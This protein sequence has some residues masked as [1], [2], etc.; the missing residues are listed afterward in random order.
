MKQAPLVLR[1]Q[2]RAARAL[3]RLPTPV[4]FRLA[5]GR[6]VE[7]GGCVLDERIQ[8]MLALAEGLGRGTV[9]TDAT[10]AERRRAL[11][12]DSL[13]FA[14]TS[15]P[16]ESVTDLRVNE[17]I[18][19]RI[20]RPRGLSARAPGVVYIHGGG[21][22]LGSLD[23]HDPVC[24]ALA[25]DV[26][27]IL[28][29]VQ[30]RLAPEHP[31]PAAAD[32]VTEAFRWVTREGTRW[33]IDPSRV[34]V[35]GDSAG[36]NLA[37]VVALDTRGDVHPPR[38]QALIYPA[39]DQTMSFPSLH[40]MAKGFILELETIRWFRE[41]YVPDVNA[42][43]NP[44]ASPWFADVTGAPPALVQTAGFDPLRDE[45]EGYAE[46]LRAAGVAVTARRYPSLVHGYLSLTG[47]FPATREPWNDLVTALRAALK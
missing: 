35:A 22:T 10:V 7:R 33:G 9:S 11:D 30:Y 14:P 26:S 34:A 4:L 28:V 16:L 3:M 1:L 27:A 43:K 42:R 37:A 8:F 25:N 17:R 19:V 38:L 24:R 5:G 36:G 12:L 20:Y 40:V 15:P 47:Y 41:N 29:A 2:A 39:V 6:R 32:D 13:V 46:K 45:G 18:A 31:F 21:F 23:S 44:R